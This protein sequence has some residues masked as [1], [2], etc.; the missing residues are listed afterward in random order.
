MQITLQYF[1]DCPNWRVADERLRA[2][3]DA[4]GRSDPIDYVRVVTDEDA[5]RLQFRGSPT[6]LIDGRDPFGVPG[7][8]VGLACR[9]YRTPSGLAGSPTVE[10]LAALF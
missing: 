5:E 2:A 7:S 6:I 10:Q 4:V 1:D 9:I 8:A 3:L